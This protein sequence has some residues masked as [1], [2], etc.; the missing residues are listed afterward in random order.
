MEATLRASSS[1]WLRFAQ[2]LFREG[3]VGTGRLLFSP[4]AGG[5]GIG[6]TVNDFTRRA[7]WPWNRGIDVER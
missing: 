2:M 4:A 5:V 1:D 7:N 3:L 6:A